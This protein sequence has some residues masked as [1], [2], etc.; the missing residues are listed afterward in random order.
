M[1][2]LP[3]S[4]LSEHFEE[5]MQGW[6]LKAAVFLTYQFDPG[7]FEQEI[8]PVFLDVPLSHANAVRLVQIEDALRRTRAPVAV[9]YDP[10]GLVL[11]GDGTAK[12]AT[13][14]IP[15]AQDHGYVFHPKN[16]FMLVE[17]KDANAKG[18]R[19]TALLVGGL[20]ANLTRSGWWENVE[21]CHVLELR[22]GDKSRCRDDLATLLRS[23]RQKS[24]GVEQ[25]AA[26]ELVLAFLSR[27]VE[28]R[29]RRSTGEKLHTHF[30]SSQGAFVD[31]LDD[32]AGD[33]LRNAN[34]EVISPFFDKGESAEPLRA[35][36]T[37]FTPRETRV[38]LPRGAGG[39]AQCSAAFH[40][41]VAALP[42]VS[43][44][45]LPAD[46][47]KR[48]AGEKTIRRYVHAKIYRF[49]H[50]AKKKEYLFV[51]S[52]NLTSAAHNRS[53][54][55]S[56]FL[57]EVETLRR[58]GF[59]MTSEDRAPT[60]FAA[61]TIEEEIG[62]TRG[63]PLRVRYH[64]DRKVAEAYWDAKGASPNL[65]CESRGV[66]VGD[67][68]TLASRTWVVLA[69]DFGERLRAVLPQCSVLTV[70]DGMGE[71]AHLL[72][73]EEGMSHKPSILLSLSAADILKFWA[74][75]SPDQRSSFLEAK[76]I[77]SAGHLDD[78][79]LVI[80]RRLGVDADSLF[81]RFAGVFHSFAAME[82]TVRTALTSGHEKE[83]TYL[84]FGEKY[85]SLG[86]LLARVIEEGG[87]PVDRYVT[88]LCAKQLCRE[89]ERDHR[90]FWAA[91]AADA[92]RIDA[93]TRQ[94]GALRNQIGAAGAEDLQPFFDWFEGWFL[95]RARPVELEPG[96]GSGAAQ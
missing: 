31:F 2:D 27:D 14:R 86:V 67:I 4:V 38:Y 94:L 8:L 52:V 81:S 78:N 61:G 89:V 19:Q 87:D 49:F 21:V 35:L 66:F 51:G 26:L 95:K 17:E 1:S 56:G 63:T 33:F 41:T 22:K 65:R 12:L 59:W 30:Y 3:R 9:Y 45:S 70:A 68:P 28:Q 11:K 93:Q 72:V 96:L 88:G 5:R 18:D 54:V 64:W 85:D 13:Q 36:L 55:E 34:L 79:G 84:L 25:H 91:H 90:D 24:R 37:R 77:E 73:Q 83:A 92:K 15:V 23:T 43:W 76:L 40:E 69:V 82:R 80:A 75:L 50:P 39:E 20:S 53:N 44:A 46:L 16:V 48:G 62:A 74:L 29:N 32:A 71:P 10:G 58:P 60:A 57:V 7:F 42:S 6:R 47:L